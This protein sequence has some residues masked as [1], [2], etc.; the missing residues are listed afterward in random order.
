MNKFLNVITIICALKT[1]KIIEENF[2]LSNKFYKIENTSWNITFFN[3]VSYW[4]ILKTI[5]F[6]A[7]NFDLKELNSLKKGFKI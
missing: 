5:L 1:E 7:L 4:V 2:I 6:S 3:T